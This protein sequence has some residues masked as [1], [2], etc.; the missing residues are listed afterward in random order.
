M[1][2]T[3]N[4]RPSLEDTTRNN[5]NMTASTSSTP[6]A[7]PRPAACERCRRR[8][9]KCDGARPKCGACA[10]ANVD[11]IEHDAGLGRRVDRSYLSFLEQRVAELEALGPNSSIF[12]DTSTA[13]IVSPALPSSSGPSNTTAANSPATHRRKPSGNNP[14][15]EQT[16]QKSSQQGSSST[17][18]AAS[19]SLP[20]QQS[21]QSQ[22]HPHMSNSSLAAAQ[23]LHPPPYSQPLPNLPSQGPSSSS[24]QSQNSHQQQQQQQQQHAA[25]IQE[26]S[27][28]ST[29]TE[30]PPRPRGVGVHWSSLDSVSP[31]PP[32]K[33]TGSQNPSAL[34]RDRPQSQ[35]PLSKSSRSRPPHKRRRSSSG[36]RREQSSLSPSPAT[37]TGSDANNEERGDSPRNDA[38]SCLVSVALEDQQEAYTLPFNELV[39]SKVADDA[40]R[41]F[42]AK[43]LQALHNLRSLVRHHL[44]SPAIAKHPTNVILYDR[45]LIDRLVKRFFSYMGSSFPVAHEITA[46]MQVAKLFTHT[47]SVTDEFQVIMMIAISLATI[48]RSHRHTSD[49]AR[50]GQD[51]CKAAHRLLGRGVL[52]HPGIER[53]QCVLLMLLYSLLVPRSSNVAYLSSMAMQFAMELNLHSD[54]AIQRSCGRDELMADLQRRIFWSCYNIDRSLSVITGRP[55]T[56]GDE[57]ITTQLPSLYEDYVITTRGIGGHQGSPEGPLPVCQLKVAARQHIRLRQ[58][59][60]IIQARLYTPHKEDEPDEDTREKSLSEWSWTMYDRL[61]AWRDDMAYPTPFV[62]K[63]WIRLQFHLTTTLLFRPSPRR[64]SPDLD[65]LHVTLHSS[66]EALKLYKA[67]HRNAAINFSWMA[68]HN[69][70]LSGLSFLHSLRE[71]HKHK[72]V[73]PSMSF[74]DCILQVQACASVLE[75]LSLSEGQAGC[76]ARDAFERVST[77]IVRQLETVAFRNSG[78]SA[79]A[80]SA[81]TPGSGQN[82][83]SGTPGVPNTTDVTG[84]SHCRFA[85]LSTED[86]H[87]RNIGPGERQSRDPSLSSG[88]VQ[89][90]NRHFYEHDTDAAPMKANRFASVPQHLYSMTP[91]TTPALT[92][93]HDSGDRQYWTSLASRAPSRAASP[94]QSVS[95]G[96]AGPQRSDTSTSSS[97]PSSMVAASGSVGHPGSINSGLPSGH[98]HASS[99]GLEG[100]DIMG[101]QEVTPSS[102]SFTLDEMANLNSWFSQPVVSQS[103]SEGF[104]ADLASENALLQAL[105]FSFSVHDQPGPAGSLPDGVADGFSGGSGM[106]F[107][108]EGGQDS[109]QQQQQQQPPQ[110]QQKTPVPSSSMNF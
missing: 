110:Q 75:A 51:F 54:Q 94:R 39:P 31:T 26:L 67:M 4:D 32:H 104:E 30:E 50:L 68:T 97:D 45:L 43:E 57:W 23:P 71:L 17:A 25:F 73:C 70:F 40:E 107:R 81:Q 3:T 24:T 33:S 37:S 16:A 78:S 58:L 96:A 88:D 82:G 65:S 87:T 15:G 1:A 93:Y 14:T 28:S 5:N 89:L 49:V 42:I 62:T 109:Q 85:A 2:S 101:A 105:G 106:A 38:L 55:T 84:H 83:S 92:M 61:R 90:D 36:R 77:L 86:G 52:S 99:I 98:F 59:Q 66:V 10:K 79:T 102:A 108:G 13:S 22:V 76:K 11:C 47:A 34:K 80:P 64:P 103:P 46:A 6:Q 20:S 35:E 29:D 9:T 53:L 12:A 21:Q 69:L 48:A 100:M 27:N 19:A 60:S 91:T 74:V 41:K 72:V 8:K 44:R 95:S 63:E 18:S 56:L 7:P